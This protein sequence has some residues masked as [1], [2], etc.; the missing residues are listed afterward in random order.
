MDLDEISRVDRTVSGHGRTGQLL[1]PIRIIV[2]L[3]EPENLKVEDLSKSVKQA[4]YSEHWEQ[5][6]G[7][8]CTAERYCLLH[9][10]VLGPGSFAGLSTFLYD[11][12]LRL[13]SYGGVKVAQFLIL[14][15]FPH[16]KLLKH[17]NAK[18]RF[19]QKLSNLE[20][21]CLLTTYRKSCIGFPK[22]NHY[23]MPKIQD[24]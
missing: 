14:A 7:H 13:R 12:G 2:R 24:G 15:Y 4:P 8:G 17:Q 5:A 23:W 11:V 16:T 18:T 9:V 1:S 21:W 22:K 20:L 10:V 19:S 6:T 3:Q